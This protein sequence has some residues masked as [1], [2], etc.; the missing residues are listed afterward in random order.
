MTKKTTR[1]RQV[2]RRHRHRRRRRRRLRWSCRS[3]E[4][5]LSRSSRVPPLFQCMLQRRRMTCCP[6]KRA[7]SKAHQKKSS[8]S[9]SPRTRQRRSAGRRG[10]AAMTMPPE[11]PRPTCRGSWLKS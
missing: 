6:G 1:P 3:P 11:E 8:R 10:S 7:P 2:R 5:K 4:S 9:R